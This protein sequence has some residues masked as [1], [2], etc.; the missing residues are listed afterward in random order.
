LVKAIV[1]SG[2]M[3]AG[4]TT[5]MAEASDLLASR[6][7]AH[8]AIDLDALGIVHLPHGAAAHDLM[9]RNLRAVWTNYA[10]AGVDRLLI[11][12]AVENRAMLDRL[13]DCLPGAQIV[14]ARLMAPLAVMTARVRQ[15]EPGMHQAKFVA[16]VAEL[17]ELL[18]AA[19]LDAFAVVN[20]GDVTQVAR[21]VL[22]RAGWL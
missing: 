4:K 2:S 15:R 20:E 19:A 22:A 17:E 10:A 12:A 13:R 21:D 16:R 1:I 6:G 7:I 3:G 9:F 5:V 14:V 11:A 8:A 18:D